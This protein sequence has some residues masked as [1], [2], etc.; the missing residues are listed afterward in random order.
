V[1]EIVI[2]V[3]LRRKTITNGINSPAKLSSWIPTALLIM[4]Y[5]IHEFHYNR[6]VNSD[7][8]CA[9]SAAFKTL[10]SFLNRKYLIV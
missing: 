3:V 5:G 9:I 1:N 4:R 10:V 8:I 6:L 7:V 2:V